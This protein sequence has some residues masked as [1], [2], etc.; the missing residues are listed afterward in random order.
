MLIAWK[1]QPKQIQA[2][3]RTEDEILFG[4]S[5]GGGKTDAGM[6]W[7]L[8][9]IANP[10]LRGLVIR[11]NADDLKDWVDRAKYFFAPCKAVC[12]GAVP[13][14]RFPSGALIRTG[15]LKDTNAY[16]KYQGHEYQRILCEELTHIARENDYEKLLG[17]CRSTVP[18]LKPQIF[19][20][21]NP[22]GI[23]FEW[24]KNRFSIPDEPTDEIII[25]TDE[26]TGRTRAF[27]PSRVQDNEILMKNDPGYVKYLESIKDP[28]LKKQWLFG[29]WAEPQIEGSYYK[30]Q[31]DEMKAAGR[32]RSVPYDPKLPVDTWWDLGVADAMSIWFTQIVGNEVRVIDYLEAEGE[33]IQYYIQELKSKNY[34]YGAHYWP[35]DGEVRELTTGTSRKETAES[36]GLNPILIVENIGVADG[37]Q[38]VRNLLPM[39]FFDADKC[40]EG[41]KMLKNY[42]KEYDEKRNVWKD[43]PCHDA[44][45]H[46]SDSFRYLA[47]GY[48]QYKSTTFSNF[49]QQDYTPQT[50]YGI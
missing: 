10:K 48:G 26:A 15:H 43:H 33:G 5:R 4:G 36:L 37:I 44:S 16:S 49:K 25:T 9:D 17:S 47:V 21:T 28:T 1:P 13:E 50:P 8:Y 31:I 24:V 30:Q 2:L 12:T 23:G 38:A 46:A 39:C 45:S 32:V 11:R 34:I 35:H 22:D 40:K 14:F 41:L 29:S 19:N 3:E 6:A 20:T 27:V 7:C 42:K 18:E